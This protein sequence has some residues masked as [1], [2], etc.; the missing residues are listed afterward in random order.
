MRPKCLSPPRRNGKLMAWGFQQKFRSHHQKREDKEPTRIAG[1]GRAGTPLHLETGRCKHQSSR[2]TGQ[3]R[4]PRGGG[5][6]PLCQGTEWER[7]LRASQEWEGPTSREGF[8][9][10]GASS[11]EPTGGCFP[12]RG[13][14]HSDPSQQKK[15]KE[16]YSRNPG[17][18]GEPKG[19]W[20]L[21]LTSRRVWNLW[22][23]CP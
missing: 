20:D 8:P 1:L 4:R 14:N 17:Y 10:R 7:G 3:T 21:G 9:G 6:A 19:Q 13:R 22:K 12:G 2:D 5:E 18:V 11:L 15:K 23:H 16:T